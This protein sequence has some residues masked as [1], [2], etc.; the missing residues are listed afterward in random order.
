MTKTTPSISDKFVDVGA[1]RIRY[2]EAGAADAPVVLLLHGASLGSSA[3]TF[4]GNL[5]AFAAAGLRAI[6]FDQPGHGLSENLPGASGDPQVS[7]A[8]AFLDA[9]Q[10]GKAALAGHSRAG[11]GA[12]QL[13][14]KDP[15]R[16]TGVV[17][18]GTGSLLPPL[19][20]V[21][22]ESDAAAQRKQERKQATVE[23]TIE[24]TRKLLEADLFHHDLITQEA[25]E[26]RHAMSIGRN[27]E[28]FSA[29]NMPKPGAETAKP[30]KAPL[31]ERL[32]ELKTPLLMLYGREDRA[33]A[34]QRA[35]LLKRQKP[36]LNL[37]II[38]RCKH[39]LPWDAPQEFVDLTVDFLRQAGVK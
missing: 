14:M 21:D 23:P 6:A 10:I 28:A 9:L 38:D 2:I 31:Y 15:S 30:A 22:A 16:Y 20:Q 37:V 3:D 33:S 39:L 11:A 1:F 17:V 32:D 24:Q 18:L 34:G 35:E 8:P 5:P 12:I 4:R 25:L 26:R 19:G 29:R 7:I 13:A 27:F 36:A